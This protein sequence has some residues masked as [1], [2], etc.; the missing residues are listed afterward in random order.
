MNSRT[1]NNLKVVKSTATSVTAGSAPGELSFVVEGVSFYQLGYG[2]F[3]CKPEMMAKSSKVDP[4]IFSNLNFLNGAKFATFKEF[5]SSEKGKELEDEDEE[6][7]PL[8]KSLLKF[9]R[10]KGVKEV[11]MADGYES[12]DPIQFVFGKGSLKKVS[13]I[14]DSRDLEY[15]VATFKVPGP[16][17]VLIHVTH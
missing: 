7:L 15:G 11:F 9:A 16:G 13:D 17:V 3:L 1:Q 4:D 2:I 12:E 8:V 6:L 14:E 5:E 10:K